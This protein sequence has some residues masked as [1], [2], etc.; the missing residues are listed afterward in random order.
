MRLFDFLKKDPLEDLSI[1]ELKLEKEECKNY[2]NTLFEGLPTASNLLLLGQ[3][4]LMVGAEVQKQYM[5]WSIDS[6]RP[7][8]MVVGYKEEDKD[9]IFYSVSGYYNLRLPKSIII[10]ISYRLEDPQYNDPMLNNCYV[11]K[12]PSKVDRLYSQINRGEYDEAMFGKLIMKDKTEY[13][14]VWTAESE[15]M[16]LFNPLTN[17]FTEITLAKINQ[18]SLFII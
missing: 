4:E 3:A 13:N 10:E 8:G 6:G 17:R 14:L 18:M 9:I 15:V 16:Q 11:N 1:D 12:R 2:R 5:K 7:I